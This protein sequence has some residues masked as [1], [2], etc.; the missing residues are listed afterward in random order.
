MTTEAITLPRIIKSGW[1]DHQT[2]EP[3][4][5]QPVSAVHLV[6]P[7]E[8]GVTWVQLG[9]HPM[10]AIALD[11]GDYRA[12]DTLLGG[13]IPRRE[14]QSVAELFLRSL[15]EPKAEPSTDAAATVDTSAV[16]REYVDKYG[17]TKTLLDKVQQLATDADY[18]LEFDQLCEQ[19]GLPGRERRYSVPVQYSVRTYVYVTATTHE[20][21]ERLARERLLAETPSQV[22]ITALGLTDDTFRARS[23]PSVRIDLV[24]PETGEY[25]NRVR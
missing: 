22:D 6:T 20:D 9:S 15:R 23:A 2:G 17:I 16:D 13:R 21:A 18:C 25:A 4:E 5:G 10:S 1:V 24:N 14:A 3:A 11:N 8:E 19:A 12:R 7:E